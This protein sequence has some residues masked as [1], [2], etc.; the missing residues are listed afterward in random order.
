MKNGRLDSKVRFSKA[1]KN[2]RLEMTKQMSSPDSI[3][4]QNRKN[5]EFQ[6]F[7]VSFI[8]TLFIN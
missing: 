3:N 8:H 4:S 1:M 5:K 2:L 7:E 6:I